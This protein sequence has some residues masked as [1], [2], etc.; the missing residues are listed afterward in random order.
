[1][2]KTHIDL[3]A[4]SEPLGN[5]DYHMEKKPNPNVFCTLSECG[6]CI[7]R[8]GSDFLRFVFRFDFSLVL[9]WF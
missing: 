2:K 8:R 4:G 3:S 9:V 6:W 7:C 5:R 1:M